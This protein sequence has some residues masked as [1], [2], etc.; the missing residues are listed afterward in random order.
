VE[1][2]DELT[3]LLNSSKMKS[4]QYSGKKVH[5]EIHL[6]HLHHHFHIVIAARVSKKVKLSTCIAPCIVQTTLKRSGMDHTA[7]NL[8]K[9][10]M[11]AFTS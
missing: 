1:L 3:H 6:H 8:I 2:E 7:F 4:D 11:P 9:N 5:A 10:T